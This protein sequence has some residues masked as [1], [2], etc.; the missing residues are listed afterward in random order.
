MGIDELVQTVLSELREISK[1]QTVVGDPIE[2]K[3]IM[4]VPVSKVSLGFG[5]AGGEA[6]ENKNP[7]EGTGGGVSI[8]PQAF[9]VVR[10]DRVELI[11]L[12]KSG[13]VLGDVMEL[14]PKVIEKVKDW[15]EGKGS[16]GKGRAQGKSGESK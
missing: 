8:E 15:K 6:S 5:I 7:Y 16:G 11:T 14:V 12:S 3:D 1:T 10:K 4:V 13:T 9:I 2:L